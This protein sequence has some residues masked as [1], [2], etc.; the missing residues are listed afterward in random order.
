VSLG[1]GHAT[2][3]IIRWQAERTLRL[4][5]PCALGLGFGYMLPDLARK[6]V[7]AQTHT[8]LLV[9]VATGVLLAAFVG[10]ARRQA[11][12]LTS[13]RYFAAPLYGRELAR[14]H[15]ILPC[16]WAL[17]FPIGIAAGLGLS[18]LVMRL[19]QPA[20]G[21]ALVASLAFGQ[22]VTA[23]IALSAC[24]RRGRDRVLYLCLAIAAGAAIELVG[25][26]GGPIAFA[27]DALAAS[28][29]G[30]VALRAFGETLARYDP[31]G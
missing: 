16:A 2:I 24:L 4:A 25:T 22:P 20:I 21:A 1:S 6:S 10:L 5:V 19:P 28:V 26:F 8:W 31:V 7:A 3:A 23:L 14:A 12:E 11:D 27:G 29:I 30:F 18:A 15:A 17:S 13:L 9:V